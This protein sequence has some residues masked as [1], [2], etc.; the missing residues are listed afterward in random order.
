MT[1]TYG[2]GDALQQLAGELWRA[3]L[4][5]LGIDLVLQPMAWE[6]QW[7]LAKANPETAQDVFVMYWWPTYVTPYDFLFSLFNSEEEPFFNLGYY[8]NPEFDAIL[9]EANILSN[10]D[11]AASEAKF[12]QA[13]RIVV[14]DAAAVF[15]LDMPNVHFTRSDIEGYVDNP[16]YGHVVFANELRRN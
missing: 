11:R 13:N 6:A 2:T 12:R 9:D 7:E 15:M 8:S 10:S 3:N 1:M 14:E 4:S 16:A 5:A